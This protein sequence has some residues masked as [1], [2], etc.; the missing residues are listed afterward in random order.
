MPHRSIALKHRATTAISLERQIRRF[1]DTFG[2]DYLICRLYLPSVIA[3]HI[4]NEF[5]L[6]AKEVMPAF[7]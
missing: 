7:N 3:S 4:V 1:T 6:L 2:T 5:A